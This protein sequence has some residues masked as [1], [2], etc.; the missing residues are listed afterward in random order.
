MGRGAVA[1]R[2]N[3]PGFEKDIFWKLAGWTFGIYV[4][5]VTTAL[6][7]GIEPSLLG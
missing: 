4:G 2:G 1:P 7:F 6:A 3:M 5:A